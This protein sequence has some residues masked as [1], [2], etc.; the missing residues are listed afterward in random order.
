MIRDYK[1]RIVFQEGEQIT[2]E[3][4]GLHSD[5]KREFGTVWNRYT[6]GSMAVWE[7]SSYLPTRDVEK[8]VGRLMPRGFKWQLAAWEFIAI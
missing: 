8:R 7:F 2:L 5:L 4:E 6:V 3:F 1:L